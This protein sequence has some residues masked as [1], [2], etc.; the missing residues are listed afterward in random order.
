[1]VLTIVIAIGFDFDPKTM[2][3]FSHVAVGQNQWY[4]FGVGA[5]PILE[6]ILVGIESDVHW[7]YDVD[8]DPWPCGDFVKSFLVASLMVAPKWH[9]SS[10]WQRVTSTATP[11]R[12]PIL[13]R[14]R[15]LGV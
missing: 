13:E 6:P 1:M 15:R 2:R 11:S 10:S 3:Y 9:R 8:F 7:G 12:L 5:P 14:A 4:N